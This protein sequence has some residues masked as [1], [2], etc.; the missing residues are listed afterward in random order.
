MRWAF[1]IVIWCFTVFVTYMLCLVISLLAHA[2]PAEIKPFLFHLLPSTFHPFFLIT[3]FCCLRQEKKCALC[4]GYVKSRNN[5]LKYPSKEVKQP[6]KWSH[7]KHSN[8]RTRT[9]KIVC[10]ETQL[11]HMRCI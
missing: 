2:W 9:W 3:L 1:G 10:S 7:V 8:L 6:G 11:C 4:I 5:V